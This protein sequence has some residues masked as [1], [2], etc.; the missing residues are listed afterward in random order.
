M[1]SLVIAGMHKGTCAASTPLV[2][3]TEAGKKKGYEGEEAKTSTKRFP[4]KKP[5][6]SVGV[7]LFPAPPVLRV[8]GARHNVVHHPWRW[9]ETNPPPFS[10]L[11][12][13][14]IYFPSSW[15]RNSY[16]SGKVVSC[17]ATRASFASGSERGNERLGT[18]QA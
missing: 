10:F 16:F 18:R 12:K 9:E 7:V 17:P 8:S 13:L 15:L 2:G 3:S 4:R 11:T 1:F 14:P 5:K 6:A